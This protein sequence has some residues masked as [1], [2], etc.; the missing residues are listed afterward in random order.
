[1]VYRDRFNEELKRCEC[2]KCNLMIRKYDNRGRMMRFAKSHNGRV[3]PKKIVLAVEFVYCKCG[4]GFTRSKFD[5]RGRLKEF[6]NYHGNRGRKLTEETRKKFSEARKGKKLSEST[7]IKMSK[8]RKGIPMNEKNRLWKGD[9]VGIDALHAYVR[10]H[11]PIPELCMMCG[12][13][14]PYDLANITDIYNREK[15]NW[16]YFCR[17]CHQIFDNIHQRRAIT[18]KNKKNKNKLLTEFY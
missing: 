13:V 1:M 4:C 2:G 11:F 10:R 5:K 12:K 3:Y 16:A 17:K 9:D 18:I 6:I 8:S 14:P 7:R 15:K